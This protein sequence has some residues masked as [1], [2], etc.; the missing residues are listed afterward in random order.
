MTL[1]ALAVQSVPRQ[2][3]GGWARC[4][5]KR[6]CIWPWPSRG[7]YVGALHGSPLET[8]LVEVW[9]FSILCSKGNILKSIS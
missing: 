7:L 6:P 9:I 3:Y 5:E 2:S 1:V 4:R 8:K